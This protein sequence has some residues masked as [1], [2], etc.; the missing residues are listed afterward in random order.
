MGFLQWK[1]R[2]FASAV[3]NF[4]SALAIGQDSMEIYHG[5]A[6]CQVRLEDF[7]EA[8]KTIKRGLRGRRPNSLLVDLA[9]HIAIIQKKYEEAADYIDQL[10]RIRAFND[11]DFRLATMLNARKQFKQALPLI[12]AAAKGPRRRFEV[13]ATL[14]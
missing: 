9:A 4:K 10:R 14:V 3:A 11:H 7:S 2:S 13:D 8:E 1:K 6:W 12:E 5:L